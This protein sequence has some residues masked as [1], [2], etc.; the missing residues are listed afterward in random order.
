MF[1]NLFGKKKDSTPGNILEEAV[2]N[3]TL[4]TLTHP[5]FMHYYDENLVADPA[6]PAWQNQ[7]IFFWSAKESFER[8]SLPEEFKKL[9]ERHFIVNDVPEEISFLQG[10]VMPWFGM[11]GGGTKYYFSESQNE[12]PIQNLIQSNALTYVELIELTETNTEILN[13]RSNYY[14]LLDGDSMRYDPAGD[15]FY[16]NNKKTTLGGAYLLGGI[17]IIKMNDE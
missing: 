6:N 2:N 1:K 3:A 12:I 17:R 4:K 10:T 15:A 14:L 7:G 8:K 13:D 11:P 5:L 16:F 9:E